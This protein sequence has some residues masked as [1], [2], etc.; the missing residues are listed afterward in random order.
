MSALA[1]A[2]EGKFGMQQDYILRMI[3]QLGVFV[4]R[5]TGLKQEGKTEEAFQTI[6]EAFGSM[7]GLNA[8]LVHALSEDDLI[9]LLRARGA[10][11]SDR[12]LALGELLREEAL[13]YDELGQPEEALPRYLKSL[14][15]HLE[16]FPDPEDTPVDLSLSAIEFLVERI[17]ADALSFQTFDRLISF[18]TDMGN[19]ALAENVL[20]ER[21]EALPNEE[22]AFGIGEEFYR[23]VLDQPD[24]GIVAGGLSREEA[25]EG[26]ADWLAS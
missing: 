4:R 20:L 11:D 8:S 14:R 13:I 1:I 3:E 26:L 15:L 25:E 2:I 17:P 6:G 19:Y 24:D 21:H 9:N 16:A 23:S 22:G 10:I 18:L 12:C 5:V 7:G